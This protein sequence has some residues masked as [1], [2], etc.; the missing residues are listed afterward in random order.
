MGQ[1]VE[2]SAVAGAFT[3]VVVAVA[4]A[5]V[6]TTLIL[7]RLTRVGRTC[8][9]SGPMQQPPRLKR[10]AAL[11]KEFTQRAVLALEAMA[12]H[13]LGA[14]APAIRGVVCR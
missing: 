14:A 2:W 6:I 11:T 9:A 4:L 7:I 10:A 5:A 3:A 1:A 12:E 13:G 8:S